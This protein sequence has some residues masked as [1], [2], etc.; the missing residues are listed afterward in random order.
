M[1]YIITEQQ[2]TILLKLAQKFDS[3]SM[4]SFLNGLKPIEKEVKKGK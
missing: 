2:K 3:L 1:E 4:F